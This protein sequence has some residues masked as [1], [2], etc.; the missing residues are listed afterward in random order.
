MPRMSGISRTPDLLRAAL[1]WFIGLGVVGNAGAAEPDVEPGIQSNQAFAELLNEISSSTAET[2]PQL[3]YRFADLPDSVLRG[4]IAHIPLAYYE[5]DA[6]PNSIGLQNV[7]YTVASD[8]DGTNLRLRR[9]Q[10]FFATSEKA[11][12]STCAQFDDARAALGLDATVPAAPIPRGVESVGYDQ[13]DRRIGEH[14]SVFVSTDSASKPCL[15]SAWIL[16]H[17]RSGTTDTAHMEEAG[18]RDWGFDAEALRAFTGT[19]RGDYITGHDLLGE[20]IWT[21]MGI[22]DGP[23]RRAQRSW[24]MVRGYVLTIGCRQHSCH[25]KGAVI[26]D[27]EGRVVRAALISFNCKDQECGSTP[28]LTIFKH[29]EA[30]G[31]DEDQDMLDEALLGWAQARVPGIPLRIVELG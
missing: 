7:H 18:S 5:V 2:Q 6:K 24:G 22:P 1:F 25:E 11:D 12:R 10:F 13:Q 29:P 28:T 8:R 3:M 9:I 19:H 27:A 23:D 31:R 14:S 16:F 17:E 15:R 4:T 26:A 30:M 20:Q 21:A